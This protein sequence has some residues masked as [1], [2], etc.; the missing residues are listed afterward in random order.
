MKAEEKF[1]NPVIRQEIRVEFDP[2]GFGMAGLSGSHLR[3]F[4]ILRFSPAI[5]DGGIENAG[6][7]AEDILYAPKATRCE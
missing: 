2:N 6:K 5:P 1:Q 3:I 7:S 4:R